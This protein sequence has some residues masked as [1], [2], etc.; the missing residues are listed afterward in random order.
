VPDAEP[1]EW[2]D[3]R[4]WRISGWD[5]P[6]LSN[7]RDFVPSRHESWKLYLPYLELVPCGQELKPVIC[8]KIG[9]ADFRDWSEAVLMH[10]MQWQ[11]ITTKGP[12]PYV[13]VQ[14]TVLFSNPRGNPL[15]VGGSGRAYLTTSAAGRNSH[16][17]R[18]QTYF[19]PADQAHADIIT[20]FANYPAPTVL[21]FIEEGNKNRSYMTLDMRPEGKQVALN[22]LAAARHEL[23]HDPRIV[24]GGFAEAL[25]FMTDN[26]PPLSWWH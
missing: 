5:E 8:F 3:Q 23:D 26:T 13:L 20:D 6:D 22:T 12:T 1:I 16:Q 4:R 2:T 9:S 10:S 25:A 24:P 7:F 21:F 18:C 15:G 11:W 19:D 14:L 17:L